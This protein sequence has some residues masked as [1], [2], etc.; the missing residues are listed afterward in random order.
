M[1]VL[2]RYELKKLLS[3]KL[4]WLFLALS[5]MFLLLGLKESLDLA[6]SGFAQGMKDIYSLYEGRVVTNV[7]QKEVKA[8]YAEYVALHQ[9]EFITYQNVE[10]GEVTSYSKGSRYYDGVSQAFSDITN[11]TTVESQQE[12]LQ[13]MKETLSR[14]KNEDGSLLTWLQQR[15]Y[16][17]M[18]HDGDT[19]PVVHYTRGWYE[20][21]TASSTIPSLLVLLTA[22]LALL[23]LFNGEHSSKMES[24][25]L[26][27]AQ[28][29]KAAAAKLLAALSFTSAVAVLYFAFNF[30]ITA[31]PY[32]LDG[33]SLPVATMQ[34]WH[35][36]SQLTVGGAYA[37][38]SLAIIL[39]AV[40]CAA[41]V[42]ISSTLFRHPL[43]SLLCAGALIVLQFLFKDS[44]GDI[45]PSWSASPF[46]FFVN[47][48]VH[49]L[50]LNMLMRQS[51]RRHGVRGI[52]VVRSWYSAWH[53]SA[54]LLAHPAPVPPAQ[55]GIGGHIGFALPL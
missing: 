9:D 42:C 7:F 29:R 10:N 34:Y 51:P 22:G 24:I 52:C 26:Y 50:P 16:E 13:S 18:I 27:A 40:A 15:D 2:L 39:A 8:A 1:A 3:R 45:V 33:A 54:L 36:S 23:P 31:L 44:F 5:F 37:L 32:G 53:H 11:Q 49:Q 48:R 12:S 35:G 20:L 41:L 17:R 21:Y 46:W 19:T 4:I 30:L 43:L 6:A 55:K 28:R 14:G 47:N 38:S 25:V